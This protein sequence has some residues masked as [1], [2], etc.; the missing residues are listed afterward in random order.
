M[1]LPQPPVSHSST[2]LVDVGN[3]CDMC[4]KNM[5]MFPVA[6]V[7]QYCRPVEQPCGKEITAISFSPAGTREQT[8][9]PTNTLR[10]DDG[11]AVTFLRGPY[12]ESGW[13]TT[14]PSVS[15]H[16]SVVSFCLVTETIP[17][18]E[19]RVWFK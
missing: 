13:V 6:T 18:A 10:I 14:P 19:Y 1:S 9:V 15:L 12:A 8:R 11:G 5:G 16:K 3:T 2:A 7:C 4:G 17:H